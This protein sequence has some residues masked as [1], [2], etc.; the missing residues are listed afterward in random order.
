MGKRNAD[1]PIFGQQAGKVVLQIVPAQ[2]YFFAVI[3]GS[4]DSF[5]WFVE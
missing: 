4:A 5:C 2:W 1:I 3:D